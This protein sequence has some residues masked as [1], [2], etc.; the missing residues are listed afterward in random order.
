MVESE[1]PTVTLVSSEGDKF[2]VSREIGQMS[3]LIQDIIEDQGDDDEIEDIPM[4]TISSKY[5]TEVIN[6]C[7]HYN[8]KKTKT[9]IAAPL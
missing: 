9:D 3:Q 4:A 8:F 5:L 7:K 1:K 6:Y 2:V